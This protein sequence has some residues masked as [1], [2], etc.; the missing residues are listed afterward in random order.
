MKV[1]YTEDAI[2]LIPENGIDKAWLKTLPDKADIKP[3]ELEHCYMDVRKNFKTEIGKQ[4]V[5][6]E[7]TK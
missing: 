3:Y 1:E 5:F 2:M 7:S 4:I 6:R